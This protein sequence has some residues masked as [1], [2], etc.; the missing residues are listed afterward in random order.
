MNDDNVIQ[1]PRPAIFTPAQRARLAQAV[2]Q[3]H[4]VSGAPLVSGQEDGQKVVTALEDEICRF[5]VE[6]FRILGQ[7]IGTWLGQ[8]LSSKL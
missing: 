4:G 1:F 8:L 5:A 2:A 6:H 3:S 7:R